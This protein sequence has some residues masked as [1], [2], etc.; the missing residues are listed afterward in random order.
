MNPRIVFMG[1]PA[2]ALPTLKMLASHYLLIG[3][4]TQP[5]RPAGRGQNLTPPSIKELALE[6]GLPIIQPGRLKEPA[7]LDQLLAWKP[8]LIVVAAFGQIL[9]QN[10][11]D[12]PP[13]G[14]INVHASL[15]PRWRGAAPIQA[16]IL[17]GDQESGVTIMKMDAGVDTGAILSKRALAIQND[18]TAESL[19][20]KLADLGA[21]LLQQALPDYL[22]GKIKPEPQDESRATKAP[23]IKKEDGLLNFSLPAEMLERQIRAFTPWPG[24]FFIWQ[25]NPLGV[26]KAHILPD[27][28]AVPGKLGIFNKFPGV[29][30]QNGWLVLDIVQPAGKKPMAGNVFLNG[31][32]QWIVHNQAG[33]IFGR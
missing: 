20:V 13:F 1:S 9:R 10:V 8:D 32:R 4:V 27:N 14:C 17:N 7:A 28:Q 6:V 24:T 19:S 5:D 18:D 16:A 2:F 26:L 11:L 29:G 3:V 31:A 30:T 12:I 33:Y 25:N 22:A 23:M 21:D 15:L